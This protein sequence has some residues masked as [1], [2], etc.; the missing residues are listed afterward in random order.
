MI[1]LCLVKML[2][3]FILVITLSNDTSKLE[4]RFSPTNCE[5][6]FQDWCASAPEL[7]IGAKVIES[8]DHF[9]YFGSLIISSSLAYNKVLTLIQ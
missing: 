1:H 9:T 3:K 8:V 6:L 4:M 7:M 2:T 5:I